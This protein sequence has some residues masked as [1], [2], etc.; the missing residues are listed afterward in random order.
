M[1][2][3]DTIQFVMSTIWMFTFV[4][5]LRS[6]LYDSIAF[7][8]NMSL[9]SMNFAKTILPIFLTNYRKLVKHKLFYHFSSITHS[10]FMIIGNTMHIS[11]TAVYAFIKRLVMYH[12]IRCS[13]SEKYASL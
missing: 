4:T 8:Q 7:L 5:A 1:C 13:T 3:R 2:D 12:A 11:L 9:H 6:R 10:V